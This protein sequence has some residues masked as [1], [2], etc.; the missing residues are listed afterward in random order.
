MA[1]GR[2]AQEMGNSWYIPILYH[3]VPGW[4]RNYMDIDVA[5]LGRGI[6]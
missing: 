6:P 1:V 5:V 4:Y 3:E 2:R